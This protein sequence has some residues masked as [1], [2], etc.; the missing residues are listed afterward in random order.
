MVLSDCLPPHVYDL[1]RTIHTQTQQQIAGSDDL[2][3]PA[4]AG[5][6]V[7]GF[8]AVWLRT[9]RCLLNTA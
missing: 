4:H 2:G 9:L 6:E 1:V 8:R 3:L 7:M 5:G